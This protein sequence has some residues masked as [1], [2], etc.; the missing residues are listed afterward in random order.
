[1]QERRYYSQ[2]D[3][4]NMLLTISRN[5]VN[6][7]RRDIDTTIA[8]IDTAFHDDLA[9]DTYIDRKKEL[10]TDR[11]A[12]SSESFRLDYDPSVSRHALYEDIVSYLGEY[13][14]EVPE[15]KY[16]QRFTRTESDCNLRLRGE[17]DDTP[18]LV[19][20]ENAVK[21]KIENGENVGK[22]QADL[23]GMQRVE[24]L[25]KDA[26]NGDRIVYASPPDKEYGYDYGFFY[27][28]K[29][30]ELADGEKIL[31]LR[32]LRIDK[33][34]DIEAFNKALTKMTGTPSMHTTP[35]AFIENPVHITESISD[36]DINKILHNVFEFEFNADTLVKFNSQIEQ[37][38][39]YIDGFIELIKNDAPLAQR[40]QAL[41][42]LEN[43]ALKLKKESSEG[44]VLY[45]EENHSQDFND[46]VDTF[47]FKP[48]DVQGT[49]GSSGGRNSNNIFG[50]GS[51]FSAARGGSL[52][53]DEHGGLTFECPHCHKTIK[54][55]PGQLYEYCPYDEC[56]KSVRC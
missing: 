38:K 31:H 45:K 40:Q 4:P 7:V 47:G 3:Q 41:H 33:A 51:I 1:M 29:V 54:R 21:N 26:R 56:K 19:F 24:S 27:D 9:H 28:G 49:C 23:K 17:K 12:V 30:E 55:S 15:Y 14:F 13:R 32:A 42:A 8:L 18:M 10:I 22:V 11:A 43:L 36:A 16:K 20:G 46:F 6:Q 35:N 25:L 52:D 48:P 34:S 53:S 2:T 50:S 5:P 39:P 44:T 37:M